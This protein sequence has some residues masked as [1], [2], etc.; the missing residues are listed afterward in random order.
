[1]LRAILFCVLFV[2]TYAAL[3]FLFPISRLR[4]LTVAAVV[5]V[6]TGCM[7]CVLFHPWNQW[8]VDARW[9]VPDSKAR[10][11]ALTFDDGPTEDTR[12]LLDILQAKQVHASFFVIGQHAAQYG[13][14]MRRMVRDGHVVGNHTFSHPSLFCFLTPGSLGQ[15][16]DLAQSAIER[17]SGVRP[18][19]FRSPVGLRHA[20]LRPYLAA[21][22][23]EYVSWRL[24]SFDT[25]NTTGLQA[26]IAGQA[27]PGDIVLLHDRGTARSKDMLRQLPGLIDDLRR[28]G[29][30]FV[31]VGG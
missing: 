23:L 27:Q 24:R 19:Y 31:G 8:L 11:I 28:R 5:S 21:R 3:L 1:M 29:Y 2:V 4:F 9:R 25:I 13:A 16:I 17:A 20:L 26:R 22:G 7:L 10:N 18:K 12:L 6:G 30:V 15:E 14:E